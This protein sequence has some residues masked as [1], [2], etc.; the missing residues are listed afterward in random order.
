MRS[1]GFLDKFLPKEFFGDFVIVST[2]ILT[3][4]TNILGINELI[5]FTGKSRIECLQQMFVKCDI[6]PYH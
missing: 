5:Y 4:Q 3:Y 2:Y 6:I 1:K